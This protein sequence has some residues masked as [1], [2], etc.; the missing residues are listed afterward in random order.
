[1]NVKMLNAKCR[2]HFRLCHIR[3]RCDYTRYDQGNHHYRYILTIINTIRKIF[4]VECVFYIEHTNFV[5]FCPLAG[6]VMAIDGIGERL[7][8]RF[9][10]FW[11]ILE[12]D[13]ELII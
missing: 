7:W 1:M 3:L 12:A 2:W 6:I 11:E 9:E 5:V 13:G 10:D 4:N 8:K